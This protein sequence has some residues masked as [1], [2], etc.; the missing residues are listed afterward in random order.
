[1]ESNIERGFTISNPEPLHAE[2]SIDEEGTVCANVTG[3][4]PPYTY[5]WANGE[6]TAFIDSLNSATYSLTITDANNCVFTDSVQLGQWAV[7]IENEF[8]AAIS[9]LKISPNPS[10]G[11]FRLDLQL[12]RRQELQL[13][14]LNL[15]G[16]VLFAKSFPQSLL[17]Q[18]EIKLDRLKLD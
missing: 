14:V 6:T 5:A 10:S 7:G 1:M 4:T 9:E 11:I 2:I 18:E 8:E 16:K 13:E 12:S 15:Q 17:L 3:G